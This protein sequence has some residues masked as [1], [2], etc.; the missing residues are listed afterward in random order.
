MNDKFTLLIIEDEQIVAA[1]IK[2]RLEY[3]G[4]NVAGIGVSYAEALSLA[5]N[6]RPDLVLMDIKLKGKTNG[7]ETAAVL[8]EKYDIPIVYVTAYA[9]RETLMK[10][11][12]TEPFGFITKPFDDSELMGVI[13]T[14]LHKYQMEKKLIEKE[15]KYRSL[16]NGINDAVFV[17]L[18][19]EK[20]FSHFI[21]VNKIACT[22]YGFT[23]KEFLKLTPEDISAP[24]DAELR[25]STRAR[26]DLLQTGKMTFEAE[27]ITKEGKRFPV[28]ISSTIFQLKDEK[29]ILSVARDIT[30]RKRAQQQVEHLNSLLKAVRDINQFIVK[31]DNLE[32]LIK[33]ACI[34]LMHTRSY[35]GCSIGLID[36]NSKR[37]M[38]KVQ[39]G[40]FDFNQSWSVTVAG[41]GLAPGC[42]KT[43]LKSG[44]IHIVKNTSN[45]DNCE[46]RCSDIKEPCTVVAV[47]MKQNKQIY[48]ILLVAIE[49]GVKIDKEELG[50]LREVAS[51][52]MFARDKFRTE[53]KLR[54][55]EE[56]FR[57]LY[58]NMTIGL[59]RTQPDGKIVI[60]NPA[61]VEMLGYDSFEELSKR[62]LNENGFVSLSDREKFMKIISE[63]KQIKGFQSAWERKDGSIIQIR[64]SA[65][66]FKDKDGN[67]EYYEGTVEDITELKKAE[68]MI[69]ERRTYL[70][71]IL[72]AAP[73]AIITLDEKHKI[74]DWN[75]AAEKMFGYT[76]NEVIGKDIDDLITD[77]DSIKE[78]KKVTSRILK[79]EYIPPTETVRN[80]KNGKPV[81]VILS[82]S[83]IIVDERLVGVIGIYT[84]I[85]DLVRAKNEKEKV[86][87]QLIQA[88]KMEAIGILTGGIAHDFNN[89]LT[90]IQGCTELVMHRIDEN[91]PSQRELKE[92]LSATRRAANL[93]S[94]LLLFSRKQP[95]EYFPLNLNKCI[96]D[97]Q[98]MLYRLIGEDI[99]VHTEFSPDLWTIWS[100]RNTI[101]QVIMNIVVNAKDAMPYGGRLNIKTQ[102]IVLDEE[103]C[104]ELSDAYPG[105]FI[106]LS[107][108]DTGIGI[109]ENT[110]QHIFEPFFSTKGPAKGT[111]LGLSV[112]YG[113]IKEHNGWINV[114]SEPGKGT[115]FKIYI[116]AVDVEPEED[117]EKLISE[118]D[119][120]GGGE[121]ILIVEDDKNVRKFTEKALRQNGY[122][123]YSVV[124]AKKALDIFEEV[125]DDLDLIFCDVVL[126]DKTGI[127][128]VKELLEK[129]PELKVILTSGYTDHRSQWPII[130]EKKYPFLQ[131]P[132]SL[133]DLLTSIKNELE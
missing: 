60:A 103:S 120:R 49:R 77:P 22:R 41:R 127:I 58:E 102:N 89:M 98:S 51:D 93:T 43:V 107:L 10:I 118:V 31:S 83:P 2:T 20:G 64:E 80:N 71:S 30:T 7:I 19:K 114:Y 75:A 33:D 14:A 9:D 18:L 4:Y 53:E 78:A 32:I 94:Q 28:E 5:K 50:L 55:N 108:E 105:K 119:L 131:K 16:F 69:E 79:G 113:I 6:K 17:H 97:L 57:H 121:K 81:Y 109:D 111:G 130:K 128:L 92:V 52:L 101:E 86:Q 34:S 29:V 126:P 21:E 104:K 122:R 85:G 76:R 82:G 40:R 96:K 66:V 72:N 48:G 63:K 54:E 68:R 87:S 13:E 25:G 39:A 26:K 23:K 56:N 110:L 99:E 100:D 123:I 88:Q 61:L 1:D 125:K 45:C 91:D 106:C 70:E 47:P 42:V 95:M 65:K 46:C 11:K 115:A 132:Y 12:E 129:K 112:V 74:K 67:I 38:L 27:H 24:S 37:I 124:N 36:E 90:A 73:D 44:D 3:L 15:E 62:N 35:L 84:D 133:N 8:K 117:M 116:P 59:Y